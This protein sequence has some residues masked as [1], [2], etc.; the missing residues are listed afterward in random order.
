MQIIDLTMPISNKT[1]VFFGSPSVSI[2]TLDTFEKDGCNDVLMKFCNHT[3]THV[4]A[5]FHMIK[6]G[7]RLDDFPLEKFIGEAIV[8]DCCNQKEIC[9]SENDLNK[10]RKDDIVFIYTGSDYKSEEYT[11]YYPFISNETAQKLMLKQI[12][13]VGTDTLSPDEKPYE[14]HKIFLGRNILIV[15]NLINLSK[16][17]GKRFECYILPLNIKEADGA[18]C[19]VIAV[20]DK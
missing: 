18:P 14:V 17:V 13:I 4:D 12:K 8:F 2:S 16:L 10:I 3:A 6:D 5:P 19:R 9:L 1:P 7:K 20:I 15:E 11:K